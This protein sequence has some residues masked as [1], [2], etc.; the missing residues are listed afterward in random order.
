[1]IVHA[2]FPLKKIVG[3]TRPESWQHGKHKHESK[4]TRATYVA[5]DVD[6]I[7]KAGNMENANTRMP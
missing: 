5:R 6:A 2:H 4:C 1:M 3:P 7:W